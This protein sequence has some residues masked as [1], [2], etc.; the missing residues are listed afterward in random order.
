MATNTGNAHTIG[1]K[2][3]GTVVA[4]TSAL[5]TY[6]TAGRYTIR[7]TVTDDGGASSTTAASVTASGVAVAIP[8][9]GAMA[10]SPLRFA[11]GRDARG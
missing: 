9:N 10:S 5:H 1:L 7:A 3:D 4:A 2:S 6:N 8:A 11:A